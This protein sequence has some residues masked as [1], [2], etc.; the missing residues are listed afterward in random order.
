[1]RMSAPETV[2]QSQSILEFLKAGG[3]IMIPLFLCSLVTWGV[4]LERAWCFR[5]LGG[6][7]RSFH[8]EAIHAL[9][10]GD[11]DALRRLCSSAYPQLPTSRLVMTALERLEAKELKQRTRWREAVERRRVLT[12]QELK[13]ALWVLGTIGSL[14]PFI[15]LF[16]TVVGIL[17]SF[18]DM[19]RTG[20]GGFA[21]VAAGISEALIATAAGIVV[22]LVAVLAYN[23]L[24]VRCAK[25]ILTVRL[26]IEELAEMLGDAD[27]DPGTR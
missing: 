3:F 12:N 1:M 19:A 25:L 9:L 22:A 14:A 2:S 5:R 8:L 24:Q 20:S 10:R 4:I 11:R 17:R 21:V 6:E 13:G 23:T 18:H 16:G 7:L 27:G 26:Q 15:G